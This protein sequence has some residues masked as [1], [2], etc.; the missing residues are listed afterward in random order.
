MQDWLLQIMQLIQYPHVSSFSTVITNE[1]IG[2]DIHLSQHSMNGYEAMGFDVTQ[3]TQDVE[4]SL[5]TIKITM[6]ISVLVYGDAFQWAKYG[7]HILP[8][9]LDLTSHTIPC[10][11]QLFQNS[12]I[13]FLCTDLD[14]NLVPSSLDLTSHNKAG[15]HQ[16]YQKSLVEFLGTD[17]LIEF[18][19]T[20][21]DGNLSF[22]L[23][24]LTTSNLDQF[25]L[26][27]PEGLSE[28]ANEDKVFDQHV[29]NEKR[30]H[31]LINLIVDIALSAT[32]IPLSIFTNLFHKRF[33]KHSMLEST[34]EILQQFYV[35]MEPEPHDFLFCPRDYSL[36]ILR[37]IR[38]R[39][40]V[41]VAGS[42]GEPLLHAPTAMLHHWNMIQFHDEQNHRES[43]L[44][45]LLFT[46]YDSYLQ[47]LKSFHVHLNWIEKFGCQQ[48]TKHGQFMFY[49]AV[50]I[51]LT[52]SK[53]TSFNNSISSTLSLITVS[54]EDFFEAINIQAVLVGEKKEPKPSITS[55][56]ETNTCDGYELSSTM[57]SII[58]S[59][60]NC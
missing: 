23:N 33:Q 5:F 48:P 50:K 10:L 58:Q 53:V 54:F 17:L 3:L 49:E 18:L 37:C 39:K 6:P 41:T 27:W 57:M 43:M 4:Q 15:P 46:S 24:T 26:T 8:S 56:N 11:H 30:K 9:N 38:C 28:T 16:T 19:R 36:Y 59:K 7:H 44:M 34:L 14:G 29:W 25:L 1:L 51:D 22:T 20:D 31:S 42:I 2:E 52:N 21:L 47:S 12:L 45:T 55:T 32:Q 13:E 60:K 40:P 35:Q